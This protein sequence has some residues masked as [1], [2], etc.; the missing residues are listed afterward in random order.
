MFVGYG[1]LELHL[2]HARDLKSKRRVVRGLVDR[3]HAR[4][5]ISVAETAHQEL[6]QRAGVGV[7]V[8]SAELAELEGL[9]AEIGRLADDL[10]EAV[11][12]DWRPRIVHKES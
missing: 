10:P 6:H 2:P 1:T 9:L 4:L 7:A 5:R 12:L 11:L 3:L 8:V